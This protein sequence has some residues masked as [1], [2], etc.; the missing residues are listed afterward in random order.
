M[1]K[2][3]VIRIAVGDDQ[4]GRRILTKVCD[5][6]H[7]PIRGDH[8]TCD[9]WKEPRQSKAVRFDDNTGMFHI[10][11]GHHDA[12]GDEMQVLLQKYVSNGWQIES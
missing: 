3:A 5:V 11:Y 9:P 2:Q 10:H 8:L 4:A 12:S 6:D 1:M 7:L